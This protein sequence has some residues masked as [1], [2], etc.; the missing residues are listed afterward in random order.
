MLR[1][2]WLSGSLV[3]EKG[4]LT[5]KTRTRVLFL[6]L[7]KGTRYAAEENSDR[8]TYQGI[9]GSDALS[10]YYAEKL[11]VYETDE[12]EFTGNTL[13]RTEHVMDVGTVV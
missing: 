10:E 4:I 2:A 13:V 8:P 3:I 11:K 5:E 1:D 7:P 9:F 12:V 6:G